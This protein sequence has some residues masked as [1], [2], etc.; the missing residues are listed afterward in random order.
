MAGREDG[1]V[2]RWSL[3]K[4][5]RC[6]LL[7]FLSFWWTSSAYLA[8]MYRLMDLGVVRETLDLCTNL[9]AYVL[10]ALGLGAFAWMVHRR[11]ALAEKRAFLA[12]VGLDLL[13]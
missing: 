6:M 11:P 5:A 9:L 3:S 1:P 12:A 13:W 7:I 10:Q 4:T 2:I 8:W